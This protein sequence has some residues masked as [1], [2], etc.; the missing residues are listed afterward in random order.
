MN[1]LQKIEF[2]EIESD[3]FESTNLGIIAAFY[4]VN[5]E[6]VVN[7]NKALNSKLEWR[8]VLIILS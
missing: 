5:L 7:F 3:K 4:N 6:T 2:I 1:N 8:E